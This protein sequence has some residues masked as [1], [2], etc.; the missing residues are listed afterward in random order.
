MAQAQIQMPMPSKDMFMGHSLLK[1]AAYGESISQGTVGTSKL[2]DSS[3]IDLFI[4]RANTNL[5][6]QIHAAI[7]KSRV[8]SLV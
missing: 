7:L 4:N 5:T 1:Q 2:S 3:A 8:R 6:G